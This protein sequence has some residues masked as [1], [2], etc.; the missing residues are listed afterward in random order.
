[1]VADRHHGDDFLAV[2]EQG[3][4]ALDHDAGLD[5]RIRLYDKII[6]GIN[7]RAP[8]HVGKTRR[9]TALCNG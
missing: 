2:E 9:K 5:R 1:M 7:M 3:K 6:H 4:R 8:C